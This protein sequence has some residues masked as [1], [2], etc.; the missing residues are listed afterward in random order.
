MIEGGRLKRNTH[1][2]HEQRNENSLCSRPHVLKSCVQ[3]CALF[4]DTLSSVE[5]KLSSIVENCG[6]YT[7]PWRACNVYFWNRKAGLQ[8]HWVISVIFCSQTFFGDTIAVSLVSTGL[9]HCF[10]EMAIPSLEER[11]K[12][13]SET[14]SNSKFVS[15]RVCEVFRS[16]ASGSKSYESANPFETQ[17]LVCFLPP[18]HFQ[19]HSHLGVF[20]KRVPECNCGK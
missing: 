2:E 9:Q 16:Q 17:K 5:F 19:M 15:E 14:F 11:N 13:Q 12:N 18:L 10:R 3:C 8:S 7:N 1:Q 6:L 20:F 4:V